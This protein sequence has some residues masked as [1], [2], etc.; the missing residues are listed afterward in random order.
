VTSG[1]TV[2]T[3][4]RWIGELAVGAGPWRTVHIEQHDCYEQPSPPEA[5]Q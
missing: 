4:M 5:A 3:R 1:D 2:V